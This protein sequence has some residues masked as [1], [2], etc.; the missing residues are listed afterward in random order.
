[1]DFFA[2]DPVLLHARLRPTGLACIDLATNRRWTYSE[3]NSDIQRATSVLCG[4]GLQAGDRVATIS[5][6]NVYQIILQQALMR[7]GAI[8]VPLNWRLARLELTKLLVDCKPAILFTD[9]DPPELPLGCHHIRFSNFV[10]AVDAA[11]PGPRLD[12]RPSNETSV[13]LYTS[14][15]SG[16]PKGVML[17]AQ[18]ILATTINFSILTEVDTGSV[19]LCDGPMFHFMGLITQI[20]PP[21]IRGGTFLVSPKFNPDVT[22]DR[23]SDSSLHVTH[24]FC[25]PQMAEALARA[26]NFDTSEWTTLKALFTGGAP[27]PPARI[28]WWLSRGIRMVDGYG[29]TEMGTV[30]GMPLSQELIGV[31]AGSVGLPGPLTA[32]RVVDERDK[33]VPVDTP[34]EILVS[35]PSVTTGYWNRPE[36]NLAAF[37]EDGWFR[38][39]DIGRV[40]EDGYIYLIDRRKNMF[41]SGGENV[42][43]AEVEAAM[44]EHPGVVD[45][46]V[47]GVPD[48]LWGE[49]GRAYIIAAPGSQLT[50]GDLVDHCR[51]LI[52]RYKVPRETVFVGDFPR[53]GSGKVQ[54]HLLAEDSV[55]RL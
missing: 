8:H 9:L 3:L 6:N 12:A 23:L 55:A 26:S 18:C 10:A 24:Y 53:T 21:L 11:E 45:V 44:A 46:A 31:K 51:S 43:P 38:S 4:Q 1:M 48:Q 30:S 27:N 22:N 33:D 52:A 42:Y 50:H 32:V 5:A 39:G 15:T 41:I 35:G 25:V 36:E 49:A 47:V 19:F 7:L 54:K 2:P 13:I 20:W 14:G 28:K 17:T 16:A 29:S 40:D 34:G 37:T